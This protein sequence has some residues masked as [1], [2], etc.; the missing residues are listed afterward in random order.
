MKDLVPSIGSTQTYSASCSLPILADKCVGEIGLDQPSHHR[1]GENGFCD[2]IEPVAGALLSMLSEVRRTAGWFPG[3]RARR[4]IKA[5][6]SMTVTAISKVRSDACPGPCL[7]Q[8]GRPR[9][10][11][12]HLSRTGQGIFHPSNQRCS[13]VFSDDTPITNSGN[14]LV[15]LVFL[16]CPYGVC[17][18]LNRIETPG[19]DFVVLPGLV[20]KGQKAL[21]FVQRGRILLRC[22]SAWRYR[23]PPMLLQTWA[24]CLLKRP[25]FREQR[26]RSRERFRRPR[27]LQGLLQRVVDRRELVFQVSA[28]AV[29]Y[30]DNRKR[31]ARCDQTVFNRRCP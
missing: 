2:R 5:V 26:Q 12:A 23:C 21:H 20:L 11:N 29:D 4:P 19:A 22:G 30:G 14:E 1:F 6:K 7:A 9:T 17:K 3:R 15:I 28:E 16:S 27:W 8:S 13:G 24:A 18:G 25:F 31:D 10:G